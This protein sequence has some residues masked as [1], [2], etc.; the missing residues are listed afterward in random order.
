MTTQIRKETELR[1][2]NPLKNLATRINLANAA[3]H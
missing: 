3:D 2:K 1:Y